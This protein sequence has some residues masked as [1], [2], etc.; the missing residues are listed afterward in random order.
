[1]TSLNPHQQ[2]LLKTI[3][4]ELENISG[5]SAIVLGGSHARGHAHAGSDLDIGIYY[6]NAGRFSIDDISAAVSCLTGT[7][8]TRVYGF[9]E[10]GP[11]V[12]GG[13]WLT[14]AGQRVD[15]IYR[16]LDKVEQVLDAARSGAY[17]LH[18]GQQPPFGFFSPTYLGEVSVALP[19]YDPDHELERLR[20]EVSEYPAALRAAVIQNSL[21]SVEFGLNAFAPKFARTADSYGVAGCLS[22]FAFHLVLALFALNRTYL[23]NDKTALKEIAAFSRKP[24]DFSSRVLQL[25]AHVGETAPQQQNSIV[26]MDELFAETVAL[27]GELYH[28]NL[29]P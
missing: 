3:R 1:M 11:W 15:L 4:G 22:R 17:E 20:R 7:S 13:V 6:R 28:S 29:S 14:L 8:D 25:L 24:K 18:Y 16:S 2:Q 27:A 21:W 26:S 5:I 9:D 19:L 23:I 10:W 12:N